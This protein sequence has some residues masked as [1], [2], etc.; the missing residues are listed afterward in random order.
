MP[1]GSSAGRPKDSSAGQPKEPFTS[2]SGPRALTA[3][4]VCGSQRLAEFTVAEERMALGQEFTYARCRDCRLVQL[5]QAPMDMGNYYQGYSYHGQQAKPHS[6]PNAYL[7]IADVL[8]RSMQRYV[9]P[10]ECDRDISILDVGCARGQY[11]SSLKSLGFHRL[12]GIEVSSDAVGSAVDPDL[13]IRCSSLEDFEPEQKYDLIT[14]NHVLEH[15]AEPRQALIK[16]REML[17]PSGR[18]VTSFPNYDSVA[19]AVFRRFWPGYDAP[20]HYYTFAPGNIRRLADQAEL[21]VK[22]IRYISRS[23][24]FTGGQQYVWNH[25]TGCRD[26][27]EGGYFRNSVTLD[28]AFYPMSVFLNR[29]RLGDMFEVHLARRALVGSGRPC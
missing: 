11:L 24:Q 4:Y 21:D 5:C 20:R 28:L 10:A 16:L 9:P 27:L 14:L 12:S 26:S 8:M 25:L 3:C 15:V 7:P 19:R 17:S 1:S 13:D 23:S 18:L 6:L 2:H 22:A 29:I